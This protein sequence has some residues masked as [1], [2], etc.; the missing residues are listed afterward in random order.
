MRS[1][2]FRSYAF[3]HRRFRHRYRLRSFTP[4]Y[5]WF[6]WHIGSDI[7]SHSCPMISVRLPQFVFQV[8]FYHVIS[9]VHRFYFRL[10]LRHVWFWLRNIWFVI[11]ILIRWCRS[12]WFS[13]WD[14]LMW[15]LW[16]VR[17][18]WHV[19]LNFLVHWWTIWNIRSDI[20]LHRW[21]RC[22]RLRSWGFRSYTFIHR[23]F[24]LRHWFRSFT[25]IH[26]WFWWHIGSDIVSHSR[27]MISVRLP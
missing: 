22:I 2:G 15:W 3:I 26:R 19:R 27:P 9:T 12:L 4:I 18:N 8:L 11:Y 1:W 10:R 21:T 24:R 23:R 5:R 7:V 25:P 6:W 13:V 20:I 17:A 14:F 16:C